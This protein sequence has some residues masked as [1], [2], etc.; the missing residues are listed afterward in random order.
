MTSEAGEEI[1]KMTTSKIT[2]E[3][4]TELM[5]KSGKTTVAESAAESSKFVPIIGTIIGG[6]ISGSLN[7]ASTIGMG[8]AVRKFFKHLVCLTAGANYILVKKKN[9]DKIF[10]YIENVFNDDNYEIKK[11]DYINN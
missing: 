3:I 4:A 2:K 8:L 5:K 10:E 1:G 7:L 9:I 11:I 6:S